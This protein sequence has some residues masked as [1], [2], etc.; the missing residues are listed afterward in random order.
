MRKCSG[1]I[2]TRR[3]KG[4]VQVLMI[5][6]TNNGV[7]THPKGGVEKG[8]SPAESAVKEVYEEAGVLGPIKYLG[9]YAFNKAGV[10]QHVI[11]Y[12]MTTAVLL[13]KYPEWKIRSRKWMSVDKALAFTKK[14]LRPM[15][16][17]AVNN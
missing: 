13:K 8:L 11:M 15:L 10:K 6:S 17:Q 9:S 5:K 1:A 16:M 2:V 12:H 14:P 7:W 4:K 3:K